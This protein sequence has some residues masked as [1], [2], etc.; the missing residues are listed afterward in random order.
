MILFKETSEI[1]VVQRSFQDLIR[2]DGREEKRK[3]TFPKKKY[4]VEIRSSVS[5]EEKLRNLS[6]F[7]KLIEPNRAII[8]GERV[9]LIS[10]VSTSSSLNFD[11]RD[12]GDIFHSTTSSNDEGTSENFIRGGGSQRCGQCSRLS[13]AN[14]D[15]GRGEQ[16]TEM[17]GRALDSGGSP[18]YLASPTLRKILS[19]LVAEANCGTPRAEARYRVFVSCARFSFLP[20]H[21]NN[22]LYLSTYILPRGILATSNIRIL[23]E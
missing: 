2:I 18:H 21:R 14:A 1:F 16:N 19:S 23:N 15:G 6:N 12:G 3:E 17:M 10:F 4:T 11:D 9:K 13:F 5:S 22:R 8:E 7:S 20:W